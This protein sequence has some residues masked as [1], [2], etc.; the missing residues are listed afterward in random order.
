[1]DENPSTIMLNWRGCSR[2]GL[3]DARNGDCLSILAAY[4]L[5][6]NLG[7]LNGDGGTYLR[8]SRQA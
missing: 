4:G 8:L 6:L 1:M 3:V 2:F 7:I 5:G